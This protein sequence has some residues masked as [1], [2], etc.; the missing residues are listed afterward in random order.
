MNPRQVNPVGWEV[1]SGGA[2]VGFRPIMPSGYLRAKHR[3]VSE[4]Q[5][6]PLLHQL[7]SQLQ[8]LRQRQDKPPPPH[9]PPTATGPILAPRKSS[10]LP[11][12]FFLAALTTF[13]LQFSDIQQV[14]FYIFPVGP[15]TLL[16]NQKA[17]GGMHGQPP[18]PP[19]RI[20]RSTF[21][22]RSFDSDLPSHPLL[23]RQAPLR[24]QC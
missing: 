15:P 18:H 11:C 19:V 2:L 21:P 9:P 20:L 22:R 16:V 12:L 13:S 10:W 23:W 6:Q 3:S 24:L 7:S 1:N 4:Q 17:K 14:R 8:L 5:P